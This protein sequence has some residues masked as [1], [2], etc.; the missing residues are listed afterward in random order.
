MSVAEL[1]DYLLLKEAAE[2]IGRSRRQVAQYVQDGRLPAVF[3]G[4]RYFVLRS[5]AASFSPPPRGNPN[6][7]RR[8][9]K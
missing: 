8:K 2:L 3:R 6:F 4:G 1:Q 9:G 5:H 7:R